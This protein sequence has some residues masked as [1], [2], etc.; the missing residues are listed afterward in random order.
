[1][2]AQRMQ[3]AV[4]VRVVVPRVVLV[5]SQLVVTSSSVQVGRDQDLLVEVLVRAEVA[6]ESSV[7]TRAALMIKSLAATMT[8]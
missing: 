5:V 6:A 3:A 4:C 2:V 8:I 1:M 7:T